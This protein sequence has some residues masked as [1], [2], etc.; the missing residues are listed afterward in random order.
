MSMAQQVD[1]RNNDNHDDFG[2]L[3]RGVP[4]RMRQLRVE[5]QVQL[6]DAQRMIARAMTKSTRYMFWATL[7]CTASSIVTVIAVLYGV[8]AVLPRVTH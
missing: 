8:F 4:P 7:A 2:G 5:A 1:E 3:A 6:A